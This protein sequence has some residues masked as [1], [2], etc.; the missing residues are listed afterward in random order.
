MNTEQAID[1]YGY[2]HR[3]YIE[4]NHLAVIGAGD[5]THGIGKAGEAF[6]LGLAMTKLY[7]DRKSVV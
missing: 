7:A 3:L 6:G 2:L 1:L 5:S 4:A